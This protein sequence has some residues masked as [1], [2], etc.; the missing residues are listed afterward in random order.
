MKISI[1]IVSWN[2]K[3]LLKQAIES[4]FASQVDAEIEVVVVDSASHDGSVAMV[5]DNF[6]QVKMIDSTENLGYARGN[7]VGV[8]AATGDIIFLL[9]PDT[10]LRPDTLAHLLKYLQEHP[11]VAAIG[12]KMLYGDGT[13]QSSR[14]RFPTIA[15]LFWESTLLEQ[16][17]PQ[18]KTAQFYKFVDQPDTVAMP[19]DW[20][21]GA[22][23]FIRREIWDSVGPL[24]EAMFMY[25]EETDWC[26]RC[27]Q[28]GW[29]IHYVPQA[30]LT[31]YE[32]QS[33]QQVVADRTIRFQR[34]KIRYAAK[35]IGPQVAWLVRLF[36]LATFAY[37]W[38][39]E[40]AKWVLGHKRAL[41]RER[42]TAYWQVIRSG[43]V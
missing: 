17:F 9:N 2:V 40:T 32:G 42:M 25:F 31:H 36:L 20:L 35:W 6:P 23:L 10:K 41:R 1:I 16:W 3:S 21:V 11:K 27:V 29:Q 39:E 5:R 14:R 19:V 37:Q 38:L 12:P 4:V 15:S 8:Q 33:S 18:N 43:L 7:N 34:S 13:A 28:L 26:H 30:V 22:A 24:D